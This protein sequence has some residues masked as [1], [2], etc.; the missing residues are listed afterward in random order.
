MQFPI[1]RKSSLN[2]VNQRMMQHAMK[3]F[4]TF[5]ANTVNKS[6]C[7]WFLVFKFIVKSKDG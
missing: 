3:H 7:Q 6:L 4:S 5:K 1:Q 2:Q